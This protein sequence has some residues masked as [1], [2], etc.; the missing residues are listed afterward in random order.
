[1]STDGLGGLLKK[2]RGGTWS[3]GRLDANF[4]VVLNLGKYVSGTTVPCL[5]LNIT[6]QRVQDRVFDS[7]EVNGV[8]DNPVDTSAHV[9]LTRGVA[10]RPCCDASPALESVQQAAD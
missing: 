3:G 5:K 9:C 1:M 8:F 4:R 6:V 10:T 7:G 2:A